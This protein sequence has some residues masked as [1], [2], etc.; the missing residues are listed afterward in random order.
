M[1]NVIPIKDTGL[2]ALQLKNPASMM[3]GTIL[4]SAGYKKGHRRCPIVPRGNVTGM[5]G[6]WQ[7]IMIVQKP[8]EA[9]GWKRAYRRLKE[10]RLGFFRPESAGLTLMLRPS[11]SLPF[12]ALMA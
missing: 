8:L 1:T 2:A 4:E 5:T 12:K 6:N 10:E 3:Q 7:A 9:A 11:I